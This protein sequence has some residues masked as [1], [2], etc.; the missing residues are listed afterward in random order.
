MARLGLL[1]FCLP[2]LVP[3][4]HAQPGAPAPVIIA[5]VSSRD[6]SD[7]VEALGTLMA[8]EMVVISSPVAEVVARVAFEEGAR[9]A[10]G[11]VLVELEHASELAERSAARATLVERRSALRR[12]E[13]LSA[14]GLA[15][16]A[17]LDLARAQML[18][19]EAM[20][21]AAQAAINERIVRAPFDGVL[22]LRE[23]S[24]GAYVQAG[25]RITSLHDLS[26]MKLEFTLPSGVLAQVDVSPGARIQAHAPGD[27]QRR[28]S[29]RI[30]VSDQALDAGSRSLRLRAVLDD[31]DASLRPGGLMVAEVLSGSR[32]GLFVPETAVI[33]STQGNSVFVNEEGR[34]QPRQVTTGQRRDGQVEVL[35]GLTAGEQV[36]V[37]GTDRLRAGVPL[38]VQSVFDGSV[39]MAELIRA[40]T[41]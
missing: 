38:K 17:E 22:G 25:Q 37:H 7:R 3:G 10:R 18:L 32:L 33:A 14:Q 40:K 19:A 23:I 34:A 21:E 15:S 12:V 13:E 5:E 4:V 30:L 27:P 9:V 36:V 35:S 6:V 39:P 28:F 8:N 2:W 29:G 24:P 31:S 26:R 20:V 41:S 11:D 16:A 1:L